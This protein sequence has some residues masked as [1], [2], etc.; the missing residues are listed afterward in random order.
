M[1]LDLDFTPLQTSYLKQGTG[2]LQALVSSLSVDVKILYATWDCCSD[3][4]R[5]QK[6]SAHCPSHVGAQGN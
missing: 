2:P 6:H 5:G 4:M 1:D 3:G